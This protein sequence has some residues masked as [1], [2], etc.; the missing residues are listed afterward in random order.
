MY[1][2]SI[3]RLSLVLILA[4][5]VSGC[6]RVTE[7]TKAVWGSSTEALEEARNDALSRTFRCSV[8]ECFNEVVVISAEQE[9]EIFIQDRK[10][11]RIVVMGIKGSVDTT[12]A[13]LFF[14]QVEEDGTKVEITS[15]STNAKRTVAN[16]VFPA[17]AEEFEEIP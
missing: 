16:A 1:L 3:Q 17:L 15:L 8:D 10:E 6:A 14:S 4:I 7:F 2:F 12:E 9:Y 5:A 13:G 11:Q